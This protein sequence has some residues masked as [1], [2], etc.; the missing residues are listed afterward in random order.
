M[1]KDCPRIPAPVK[2]H[3]PQGQQNT[4]IRRFGHFA[5][6]LC[7]VHPTGQNFYSPEVSLVAPQQSDAQIPVFYPV[8]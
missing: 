1:L 8:S 3:V 2:E 6:V 4:E 5:I 7:Q